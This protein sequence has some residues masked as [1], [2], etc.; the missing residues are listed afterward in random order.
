[1]GFLVDF[2]SLFSSGAGYVL[3]KKAL[4]KIVEKLL[5]ANHSN[6]LQVFPHEKQSLDDVFTGWQLF[7]LK[8][9]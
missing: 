5:P 8:I 6:C 3:S 7:L 9:L 2:S 1:V 4:K